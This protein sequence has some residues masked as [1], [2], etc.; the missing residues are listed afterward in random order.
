MRAK[1][2][3]RASM[4]EWSASNR[5]RLLRTC[6][7]GTLRS[8]IAFAHREG[9]TLT[10]ERWPTFFLLRVP[11]DRCNHKVHSDE[12]RPFGPASSRN[13]TCGGSVQCKKDQRERTSF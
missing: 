12:E 8:S 10:S 13:T 3:Q 9:L 4:P 6:F 1:R 7:R 2:A 11:C 5:C